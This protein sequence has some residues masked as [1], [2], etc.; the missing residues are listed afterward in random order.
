MAENY[1][2]NMTWQDDAQIVRRFLAKAYG[3]K[4]P[5]M[6]A[7]DRLEPRTAQYV[8]E[9]GP[10]ER[11]VALGRPANPDFRE[12][13]HG[14]IPACIIPACIDTD[15]E[16]IIQAYIDADEELQNQFSL[17]G[18]WKLLRTKRSFFPRGVCVYIVKEGRFI[19]HG[20]ACRSGARDE[21][22]LRK[23]LLLALSAAR[24]YDEAVKRY[25]KDIY[26]WWGKD[27]VIHIVAHD[28][29]SL[30][31]GERRATLH[32]DF[33]EMEFTGGTTTS[34]DSGVKIIW[35]TGT[36][37]CPKP[38]TPADKMEWEEMAR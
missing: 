37:F 24:Q 29:R 31:D 25:G 4:H 20:A 23:A 28:G 3:D 17:S 1:P 32:G 22:L 21:E 6:A 34:A 11:L 13:A 33:G 12:G 5:A 14:S 30:D 18:G 36:T 9:L 10:M 26:C 8:P 15:D 19:R 38:L 7:L 35:N 2:P 27:G 16:S